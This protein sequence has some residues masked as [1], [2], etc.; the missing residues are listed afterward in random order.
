MKGIVFLS[1]ALTSLLIQSTS[2]AVIE[3]W[4]ANSDGWASQSENIYISFSRVLGVTDGNFSLALTGIAA[5][6]PTG[7]L[8]QLLSPFQNSYTTA[9]ASSSALTLDIYTPPD[10]FGNYLLFDVFIMNTDTGF[11]QFTDNDGYAYVLT[12]IGSETTLTFSIPSAAAAILASSSHPTQIGIQSLGG[13][14][15]G[16]ETVYLDNLQTVPAPEP[17][18]IELVGMCLVGFLMMRRRLPMQFS[19]TFVVR[20][21]GW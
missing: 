8:F 10:S 9:L 13:F 1:V 6:E 17:E 3:S 2:A 18:T 4:E 12:T 21:N 19:F 16:N 7:P 5:S 15:E 20:Q 14:S 11:E